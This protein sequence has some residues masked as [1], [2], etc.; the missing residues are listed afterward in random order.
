MTYQAEYDRLRRIGYPPYDA[1]IAANAKTRCSTT[2]PEPPADRAARK[3][4]LR[5]RREGT[6]R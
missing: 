2:W 3:A 6:Q 1:A 4:Q 5:T